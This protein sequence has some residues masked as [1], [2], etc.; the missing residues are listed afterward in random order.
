[1]ILEKAGQDHILIGLT[2]KSQNSGTHSRYLQLQLFPH[3]QVTAA[4][5]FHTL[6]GQKEGRQQVAQ[7]IWNS[8]WYRGVPCC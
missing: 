3:N 2:E 5:Y 4:I 8:S 6:A 1:V 7:R